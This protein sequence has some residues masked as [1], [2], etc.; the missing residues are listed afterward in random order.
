MVGGIRALAWLAG[1]FWIGKTAD[2]MTDDPGSDNQP[3]I[4]MDMGLLKNPI[5]IGLIAYYFINKDN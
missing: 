1:I 4:N 5:V 2:N 3:Y